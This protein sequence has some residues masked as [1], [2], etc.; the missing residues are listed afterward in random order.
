MKLSKTR[1]S[2]KT[3]RISYKQKGGG[4]DKKA[5]NKGFFKFA[6]LRINPGPRPNT[7]GLSIDQAFDMIFNHTNLRNLDKLPFDAKA[8]IKDKLYV[9]IT[10]IKK[11]FNTNDVRVRFTKDNIILK[12]TTDIPEDDISYLSRDLHDSWEESVE[13][14]YAGKDYVLI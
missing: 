7:H 6:I 2:K 1:R 13:F 12:F 3:S 11:A 9:Y 5:M 4:K 8:M 10:D 14:T